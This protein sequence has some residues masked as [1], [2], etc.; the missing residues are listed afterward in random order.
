M[1]HAAATQARQ[2]ESLWWVMFWTTTIVTLVV[3]GAL[4]LAVRRGV[5]ARSRW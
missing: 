1:A 3:Y 2:V 4:G 5:T